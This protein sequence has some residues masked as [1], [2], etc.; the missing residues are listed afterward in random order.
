MIYA[1]IITHFLGIGNA[2][3]ECSRTADMF[4]I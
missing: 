2:I 3:N 4:T 1:I